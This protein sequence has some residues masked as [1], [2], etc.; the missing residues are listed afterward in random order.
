[1][2]R[3]FIKYLIPK[4]LSYMQ[5]SLRQVGRIVSFKLPVLAL[6]T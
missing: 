5:R 3:Y 4:L 1:M 2:G 6:L